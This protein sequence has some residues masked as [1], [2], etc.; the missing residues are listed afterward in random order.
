MVAQFASANRG[1]IVTG[2]A[3]AA[4]VA[5]G[6]V[7]LIG[8]SAALSAVGTVLGAA[9]AGLTA[10]GSALA[11]VATP[12][13]AVAA[14]LVALGVHWVTA[15]EGGG[16]AASA[17]RSSFA[18]MGSIASQTASAIADAMSMGD[19]QSAL[20]VGLAGATA[21]WKE[22]IVG[23]KGLWTEFQSTFLGQSIQDIGV[24]IKGL[25]DDLGKLLSFRRGALTGAGDGGS[26][27]AADDDT[28]VPGFLNRTFGDITGGADAVTKSVA[29]YTALAISIFDSTE[30]ARRFME[31][32][33]EVRREEYEARKRQAEA[34]LRAAQK[35]AEDARWNLASK[36][37][38][39]ASVKKMREE[40]ARLAKSD[41]ELFRKKK[42]P[43]ADERFRLSALD[44]GGIF[45]DL[46]QAA[47]ARR[48]GIT[49][50]KAAIDDEVAAIRQ[51]AQDEFDQLMFDVSGGVK[52]AS[53]MSRGGFGGPLAA[54]FGYAAGAIAKRTL[55]ET[56]RA[57]DGI[58]AVP[59]RLAKFL[60]LG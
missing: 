37:N 58:E 48:L 3:V 38:Y 40:E 36:A 42:E 16:R 41:L 47:L 23:W 18:E 51:Q 26:G 24:G 14:G 39:I 17:L 28:G 19:F 12:L 35:E 27:A 22:A 54:Q 45:R 25:V 59:E 34:S 4:A 2:V 46:E 55:D 13:G 11:F 52:A 43:T 32:A 8:L 33:N 1:L 20:E 56:S 7:A 60:T 30:E 31:E 9:S 29:G 21:V 6:G 53:V 5:L 44:P 49:L 15:T 10:V 57:A 50:P